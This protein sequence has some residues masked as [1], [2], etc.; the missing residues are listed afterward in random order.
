MKQLSEYKGEYAIE[1]FNPYSLEW[2]KNNAPKIKN[3]SDILVLVFVGEMIT[4]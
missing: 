4:Q 3:A 2:F 1:S